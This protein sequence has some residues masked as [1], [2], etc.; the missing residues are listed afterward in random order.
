MIIQ[1]F[2]TT[3]LQ[4]AKYN[5]RKNLKPGDTEYE[6]LKASI[7][8]FG[9]VDPII[10]NTRGGWNTV[11]GGHQRLKVLIDSGATEVE[12]SVVDLDENKEKQLNLAMNKIGNIFDNTK[13][14]EI[15]NEISDTTLT[16]FSANEV[17][18][19]GGIFKDSDIQT[20]INQIN[21]EEEYK[22]EDSED[23]VKTCTERLAQI[24]EKNPRSQKATMLIA[25]PNGTGCIII[26]DKDLPDFVDE[27]KRNGGALSEVLQHYYPI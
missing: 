10:V 21:S 23:Y 16:G 4:P 5:P 18:D 12:C 11:V 20:V 22:P 13:L 6:K 2:K 24:A 9:Y 7:Q 27:V 17:K 1:K 19:I 3:E 8:E 15:F 14:A 25:N 26:F